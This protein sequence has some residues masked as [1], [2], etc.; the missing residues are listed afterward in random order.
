M[1][2]RRPLTDIPP[3]GGRDA[4]AAFDFDRTL[5]RFDT[6]LIFCHR[7]SGPAAVAKALGS[8][9]MLGGGTRRAGRDAVKAHLARSL[10]AGRAAKDLDEI[11]ERFAEWVLDHGL[12][13]DVVER[14]AQHRSLG[15]RTAIVSASFGFYLHHVGRQLGVDSVVC[16]EVEVG[17]GGICTGRLMGGNCRGPEKLR[18]LGEVEDLKDR[19][20]HAYGDSSGDLAL[21]EAADVPNWV[22]QPPRAW[23]GGESHKRP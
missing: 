16:T 14:L 11:G 23:K 22:R 7:A 21:L 4:I 1:R 17:P 8:A 18:R 9:A 19:Q 15:H 3:S 2:T 10:F 13:R 20:L 5:T 6:V 12:R